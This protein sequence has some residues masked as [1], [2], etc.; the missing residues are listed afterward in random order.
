L[1][2]PFSAVA[3]TVTLAA[4][5]WPASQAEAACNPPAAGANPS[6]QTVNCSLTTTNQNNP[7]GYGT[8]GQNT[9]TVNVLTG[10]SVTG[11][12][13]GFNLGADNIINLATGSSVTGGNQGVFATGGTTAV[14]NN[15]GTI[16][17]N[18]S[19]PNAIG[20]SISGSTLTLNNTGTVSATTSAVN[21]FASAV[22]ATN[23]TITNSGTMTAST[24]NANAL[25]V[26]TIF[27]GN[28]L[29]I[30]NTGTISATA[31]GT[32]VN[33]AVG[34]FGVTTTSIINSGTISGDNDGVAASGTTTITNAT[35][36]KILGTGATG[37]VGIITSG[38]LTLVNGGTVAGS[39]NGI[40]TNTAGATIITNNAGGVIS[41]AN[42]GA[43]PGAIRANTATIA[44]FGTVT[45][46]LGINF[47]NGNGPSTIFNA[48][49]INGS[50][51]TAIHFSTG[52]VGN[53]LTLAPGFAVNGAVA[54]AGSDIFQLG[55]T[56]TGTFNLSSIGAQ[57]YQ[58]FTTFNKIDSST[59]TVTGTGN[60]AWTVQSGN[61][62]VNGTINGAVNV[63]GGLLGGTGAVG[64][65][66]IGNGATLSPGVN[67]IGTLTVNGN[68]TLASASL[69]LFGVTGST[70]G[71]TTVTGSA[72]VAGTAQAVFQGSAFQNQYTVLSAAG[73]RTGT[74]SNFTVV[75]LPSFITAS[76]V[77]T[78]TEVDLKLT[79][80]LTQI[81]GLTRNQ[82]AVAGAIDRSVN[83]GNGFLVGL[84]SVPASQLPAALNALS[85]EGT[86]GTQE[87]ALGAGDFFIRTMME[88]GA[89]WR[90]GETQDPN[91]V[92]YDTHLNYAA[93]RTL[94]PVFKAMPIKTPVYEPRYRAW[95]AGFDGFWSLKGEPDPGSADLTHRTAGGAAGLDYRINHDLLVGVA[96]GGSWS[97]FSVPD[98]AT[99]GTLDGAHFGAYGVAR[100]GQWYAAG[101]LAF[102]AF[103]NRT[104]RTI[105]GVGP[106][107]TANGSFRS[108]L[109]NGRVEVGVKQAFNGI[110]VSPFAAVQFAELW[111]RGYS[112]TGTAATGTPGVLGLTYTSR[113]VSSLPTFLGVQ[114]DSRVTLPNGMTWTPYARASWVHE[115]E[116]TRAIA[117]AFITLPGSSFTVDGPRAARDAARIDV[118]SK[119]AITR[120]AS[121][122]GSFDGEFSDRSRMYAGKGGLRVS[123]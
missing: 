99:G 108:D 81:A 102:N 22:D 16:S 89:F 76:L 83:S 90:S 69:Y 111:Q 11:T 24:T 112:E 33:G 70:S 78:P 96:A 6:G 54:G 25:G 38:P 47:R 4:A 35:G 123:W 53:T 65:T 120:N 75:N 115:F 80:G 52:S 118:G 98:R 85:G 60:Q 46:D 119:L 68:L 1:Q 21:G 14:N 17:A 58:G 13:F 32:T 37:S 109:L 15:G 20:L 41:S 2:R 51:G 91:G 121:L 93:E 72:A 63:T 44:N 27:V 122:F 43:T 57:Q 28:N 3:I 40:N 86:S 71:R 97:T 106:S 110:A 114:F 64:T 62:L 103:D 30:M 18:G 84:A 79:S 100:S 12:N 9:D 26:F 23:A 45:G 66:S 113:A 94:P 67:G 105:V 77:Y 61:F 8:S 19:G 49:T 34:V 107:E 48:G 117:A 36:G 31:T 10:A 92:T 116:P 88:Q 55:G 42:G 5:L 59:W 95:A 73:G 104:N 29:V 39:V 56:G 82:A 7:D 50:G 74:F 87:T 101:T